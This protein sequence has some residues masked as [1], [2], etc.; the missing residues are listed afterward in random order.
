MWPPSLLTRLVLLVVLAAVGV[1]E[2]RLSLVAG[3]LTLMAIVSRGLRAES[4]ARK[5]WAWTLVALS[6]TL[7]LAGFLRFVIAEA[8]PGVIAG[9][10]AAAEK[11]AVAYLRTI[12]AAEDYMRRSAHKD[13]DRDGVGSAGSLA[14]LA[15]RLPRPASN[16]MDQNPL[17][18]TADQW[19]PQSGFIASG[20]YIYRV[21]LPAVGGG[22]V[23]PGSSEPAALVDQERAEREYLVYGWPKTWSAGSPTAVYVSDA[24]EAIRVMDGPTPIA[25]STRYAGENASAPCDLATIDGNFKPWNK[26]T[27]RSSLPGDGP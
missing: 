21:C 15:G 4:G 16:G 6:L 22:W 2:T 9:G 8:I 12:V 7:S 20:A 13:H 27:P 3:F 19:L 26:K 24:Y 25:G 10:R 23:D 18:V 11:H 14:E 1:W 17:Y 5:G